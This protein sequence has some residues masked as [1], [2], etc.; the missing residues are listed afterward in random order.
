MEASVF[1]TDINPR[2]VE[3]ARRSLLLSAWKCDPTGDHSGLHVPDLHRNLVAADFLATRRP[4]EFP[5]CFDAVL[6]GPPFVRYSQLRK[7]SPEQIEGWR[8]RFVTARTGQFDLYMPFFE[9]AVRHLKPGGRLGWSVSNT[10]LRSKFGGPLRRFLDDACNVQELVEFENPRVYPDAV[11]QIVLVRLQKGTSDN[12]SRHVQVMGRPDLRTALGAVAGDGGRTEIDLQIRHL[13]ASTIR[14]DTWRLLGDGGYSATASAPARSLKELGV[15]VTQ[16]V[17]TGADP[18]FLLQVVYW[19]QSG[20]TRVEDREGRQHLI[21][22]A[23]LRP[24]VR[25]REVHGYSTPLSKNHLLLPYD[26]RGKVLSEPDLAAKFPAAH[27]YL[28][29]RR[30]EIP[31]TGRHKRPFYAFRNDAILRLP[32]GPRILVGMVTSGAD[33]TL[34]TGGVA[35]P[36]AGVLV[37]DNLPAD[38]DPHF[39]L[40]VLNSPVFWSFVRSTMPTLGVGRHVLRRE[41]LAGFGVRLPSKAAQSE[42]AALVTQRMTVPD[43]DE[44][45][46]LKTPIDHAVLNCF[47]IATRTVQSTKAH[48]A[49]GPLRAVRAG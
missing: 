37:L 3:W 22:S 17:V 13:P 2:A 49:A 5:N 43:P 46:R 7:T 44:H 40:A 14:G 8:V 21:E 27:K 28:V 9:Q 11:T 42:I 16:G 31:V 35:V 39:L 29:G 48:S 26:A 15:R 24:A 1:G 19:G 36:H 33:A 34:D 18:F 4:D 25:S 38:L 32:P 10:F 23:L 20:L 41:P 45:T 47:G 30:S 12:P 6:G